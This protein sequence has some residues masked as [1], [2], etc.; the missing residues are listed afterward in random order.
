[1]RGCLADELA[2]QD[3]MLNDAYKAAMASMVNNAEKIRLRDAEREWIKRTAVKCNAAGKDSA[4]GSAEPLM[5]DDCY[6]QETEA[7]TLDLREI[8]QKRR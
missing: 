7:R 6:I 1:M 2:R 5:I 4:G 8:A 3:K